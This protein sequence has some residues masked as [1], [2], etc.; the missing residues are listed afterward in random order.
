MNNETLV[1]FCTCP[2][3]H[4]AESIARTLVEEQLGACV[5]IIPAIRSVYMWQGRLET[6]DES[7]IMIKTTQQRYDALQHR[8]QSL[9]PYELPEIIAV[10]ITT[11]LPGYLSWIGETVA[12]HTD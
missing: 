5:N 3:P 2:D 9:H 8:L 12:Q 10:P 6:G 11:G 1:V 7:L 4:C